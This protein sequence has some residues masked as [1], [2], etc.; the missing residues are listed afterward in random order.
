LVYT[1]FWIYYKIKSAYGFFLVASKPKNKRK[2]IPLILGEDVP[3][4]FFDGACQGNLRPYG[5]SGSI[6]LIGHHGWF[7]VWSYP[8]NK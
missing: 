8:R 2:V 7:Q 1:S 3:W 5:A 4:G 6:H